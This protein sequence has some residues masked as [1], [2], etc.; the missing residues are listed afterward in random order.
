MDTDTGELPDT[1]TGE[2]P[3]TDSGEVHDTDSAVDAKS[4]VASSAAP[5]AAEQSVAERSELSS[6]EIRTTDAESEPVIPKQAPF[7]HKPA[8]PVISA[9]KKSEPAPNRNGIAVSVR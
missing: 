9:P 5:S 4:E 1:D 7:K 8:P 6:G 3:D 2:L